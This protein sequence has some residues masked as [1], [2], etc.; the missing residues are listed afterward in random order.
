MKNTHIHPIILLVLGGLI[1]YQS[2]VNHGSFR[3]AQTL[4]MTLEAQLDSLHS[5][6]SQYEHIHQSYED[7]YIQLLL[8]QH[9]ATDLSRELDRMAL[10]Q[11]TDVMRIRDRLQDVLATYDTLAPQPIP[12]SHDEIPFH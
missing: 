11:Q 4:S 1:L 3:K 10:A 9:H 2:I 8:S 12:M 7:L 6:A 5:I